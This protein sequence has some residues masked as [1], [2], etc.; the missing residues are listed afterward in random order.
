MI[1]AIIEARI[2]HQ[3]S[4]SARTLQTRDRAVRSVSRK[5]QGALA[6]EPRLRAAQN[7]CGAT[8]GLEKGAWNVKFKSDKFIC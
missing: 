8:R 4:E 1:L 2:E 3:N 7:E 6:N 5:L